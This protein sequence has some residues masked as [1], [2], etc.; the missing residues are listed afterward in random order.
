MIDNR[1]VKR[2]PTPADE[3]IGAPLPYPEGWFCVGTTAQLRRTPVVTRRIAGRDVVVHRTRRG[4]VRATDPYCPHLGAHLG[5]AGR[6]AGEALVC[7]FHGF[8]FAAD[9]TCVRTGY[10]DRT[11]P[12][13]RLGQWPVC[14]RGGLVFVW[15]S[16]KG[17]P[18]SWE[19]PALS[20]QGFPLTAVRCHVLPGHPQDVAENAVDIGHLAVFHKFYGIEVVE[21]IS[22]EGPHLHARYRWKQRFPLIGTRSVEYRTSVSGLGYILVNAEVP[23]LG[24]RARM[25]AMATPIAPWRIEFRFATSISATR[26]RQGSAVTGLATATL[27]RVL[28]RAALLIVSP[29]ATRDVPIWS[30][31]TYL[32]HPRLVKGDGPIGKFRHWAGQFYA[33]N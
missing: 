21:P 23:Q 9:G 27:S 12:A 24:L 28:T 4:V 3:A 7:G 15:F 26:T 25:W 19:P 32:E 13:A 6:V 10:A 14:E 29:E 1:N 16:P 11:P 18:P 20:R 17:A 30:T 22:F 31:K 8:A 33:D 5:T 2:G